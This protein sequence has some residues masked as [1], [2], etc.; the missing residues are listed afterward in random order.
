M[1]SS[2]LVVFDALQEVLTTLAWGD[3]LNTD[4]DALLHV[5]MANSLVDDD[6]K[7]SLGDIKDDAR[8]AMVEFVGHAA[9]NSAIGLDV[10]VIAHLVDVHV[11]GEVDWA[12]LAEAAS[13]C[14]PSS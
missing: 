11:C 12:M 5:S 2:N 14:V 3:M 10:D 1:G 4:I 13:K 7:G 6:A 9:M 8:L